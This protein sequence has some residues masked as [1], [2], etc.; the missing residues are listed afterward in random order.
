MT[1]PAQLLAMMQLTDSLFP[2]GAF[3]HSNGLE[4]YVQQGTV[5][6]A[7]SLYALLATRL[8]HGIA[9][10]D[11]IAVHC[12]MNARDEQAIQELDER[13]SAM[14]T[15][16]E[17]RDASIK[18]GKQMLR[19][20]LTLMDDPALSRYQQA[21]STGQCA[22]HHAIVHGLVYAAQGI[23]PQTALLAFAYGQ[24]AGQISAAV[25]LMPIGQTRAQQVLYALIPTMQQAVEIALTS[26]TDE[27]QSFTPALEIHTM[28][29][30]YLFRRLFSS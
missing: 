2:T 4:T 24:T 16:K 21:I 30:Q 12:A 11:M 10:S 25:K 17:G 7:D 3:T 15:A 23:D 28:Q 6:D 13:L 26:S 1:T 18:V 27:M 29:H 9:R 22:G 5:Q 8:L 19:G 20:A 14:K